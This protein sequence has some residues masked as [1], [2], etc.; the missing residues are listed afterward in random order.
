MSI[1]VAGQVGPQVLADGATATARLGKGADVIVSE[2]HGRFY[3]QNYRGM[4]FSGG[5]TALTSLNAVTFTTATLGPTATPILG[6]WNPLTSP[7]NLI[8]MHVKLQV[9]LTALQ[10]T[11][12][13]SFHWCTS[14][15]NG[16][17]STGVQGLN[18]KTLLQAGGF[19]K[20]VSGVALT[21][22]TNNLVVRNA[23]G[24]GGG[25]LYNASLLGT[26]AGFG[27]VMN[28]SVE[29]V[30]GQ[31][32]IPPGGVLAL[33]CA[34]TPVAHSAGGGILWTEAAV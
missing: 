1:P 29:S 32:M 19:G 13:G 30:D 15:G 9:I 28:P 18:R 4:L 27:T 2:L 25:S 8:V 6:I 14:I 31:W 34:T 33:L 16:A 12:C 23:A 3:E 21:G 22:L 7:V 20:D 5:L 10:A 26:A 11:G 24:I 17:I